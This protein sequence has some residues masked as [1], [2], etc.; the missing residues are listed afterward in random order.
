MFVNA[1]GRNQDGIGPHI[2]SGPRV[3]AMHTGEMHRLSEQILQ[4]LGR[5]M[6]VKNCF[7]AI[8]DRQ[9]RC[10]DFPLFQDQFKEMPPPLSVEEGSAGYVFRS[11]RP[12]LLTGGTLHR[13]A[14]RGEAE[15]LV[16]PA[17]CWI[18][19]PVRSEEQILGVLVVQ[20]YENENAFSELDLEHLTSAGMRAGRALDR[21]GFGSESPAVYSM[22]ANGASVSDA[23][24]AA[25]RPG[26][27][28]FSSSSPSS[29]EDDFAAMAGQI[30]LYTDR[31]HS[32]IGYESALRSPV[33]QAGRGL[34][35]GEEA[36]SV[37]DSLKDHLFD[38]GL[39]PIW[40]YDRQTL[41]ILAAN[42]AAVRLF[43]YSRAEL[44]LMTA[45]DLCP[46]AEERRDPFTYDANKF[47]AGSIWQH[48]K[49]DGTM[50]DIEIS[51]HDLSFGA[52]PARLVIA[53]NMNLRTQ[54]EQDLRRSEET[55]ARSAMEWQLTF[56]AIES[57]VLILDM[58]GRIVKLNAAAKHLASDLAGEIIGKSVEEIGP[59]Q[60]WHKA[61]ELVSSIR[62]SRNASQ[63]QTEDTTTG[64]SWD[65]TANLAAGPS[66]GDEHIILVMQ[67]ITRLV[68]LQKSLHQS[69]TMSLLGTLISGVAHEVR[70]PLF[71]ISSTLDAFEATFKEKEEY[72]S[73]LE[74]LRG[75][76]KRM[77]NLMKDL[78]DYGR[79]LGRELCMGLFEEIMD[80]SVAAC[81]P[82]AKQADVKIVNRTDPAL[83]PIMADEHRLPQVFQN[84]LENAIQHSKPGDSVEIDAEEV[85]KG[86]QSWIVCTIKDNG[87]GIKEEDLP[88]LFEPFFT[89]RAGGTG[90][91]LSIVH[92]LVKAH[93][94][95]ITARNRPEGG[96]EME[97][98]LPVAPEQ[99]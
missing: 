35:S 21:M 73:Y 15:P 17:R 30:P 82:L 23:A 85:V 40:V 11:G 99:F 86:T 94:G 50:S 29:S 44:F 67:E 76:V 9:T 6:N 56:D 31:G 12:A 98:R 81:R 52:V 51:S 48:R 13:L 42:D 96:A 95:E 54:D 60:P 92:R 3:F 22:Y 34:R 18:G 8:Y 70:N 33:N 32:A 4:D 91:G 24:P 39:L 37:E 14:A 45:R 77:S 62:N 10:F 59:G 19:A 72:K 43:G 41:A 69:E 84:L 97:V 16:G 5:V 88:H 46:Y 90:L 79:P 38:G 68:E 78:L 7:L 64:R 1:K 26:L 71:G 53:Q 87:P 25:L 27:S 49:K 80:R 66:G 36:A 58:N 20:D 65:V 93:G 57:P 74:V 83:P 61:A 2:F 63:S 47:G 55:L 89:R 28:A 75:E